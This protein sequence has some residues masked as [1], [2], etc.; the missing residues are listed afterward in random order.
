M[1]KEKLRDRET[2]AP[3]NIISSVNPAIAKVGIT[4]G[5]LILELI[6]LV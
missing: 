5:F 4:P 1:V 6:N 2:L 3:D